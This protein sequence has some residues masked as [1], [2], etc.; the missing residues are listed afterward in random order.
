MTDSGGLL[1]A[2]RAMGVLIVILAALAVGLGIFE[3]IASIF[4]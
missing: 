4:I 3:A 2:C 1:R